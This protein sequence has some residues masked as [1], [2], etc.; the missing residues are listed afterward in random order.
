MLY[1]IRNRL[2]WILNNTRKS[3]KKWT[4]CRRGRWTF[5]HLFIDRWT[6]VDAS[7]AS[8]NPAGN[9]KQHTIPNLFTE[10]GMVRPINDVA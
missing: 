8:G 6:F 3:R 7:L 1:K 10:A 2:L 9:P 5:I 4:C